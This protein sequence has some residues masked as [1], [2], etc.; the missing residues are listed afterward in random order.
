MKPAVGFL[1]LMLT[2]AAPDT[3]YF[4]FQREIARSAEAKAGQ[5]CV[6]LDPAIFAHSASQLADLRLYRDGVA[7]TPYVVRT[8]ESSEGEQRSISLLNLGKR[9]AETVFDAEMPGAR[10]SDVELTVA[11]KDFIAAVT[12][13]GSR[14]QSGDQ[15]RLGV[16]TIFD[17][18]GQKLGRSTVL[19]LPKS[20]FRYLHFRVKGALAPDAFNGIWVERLPENSAK[21]VTVAET[22]R[23]VQKGKSTSVEF[24]VPAHVPV[25]RVTFVA[26]AAPALFSRE[27]RV[28]VNAATTPSG[29]PG[30]G[31]ETGEPR[32]LQ[33]FTGALLR[34]HGVRDG[35]RIDE[36]RLSI[37]APRSEMDVAATWT[38]E[39]DNGDDAPLQW[40]AVRLEMLV[41][42]ACFEAAPGAHYKLK[43]GDS[44]LARPQ[45]DYAALFSPQAE[46]LIGIAGAE[47]ANPAHRE[48]PDAR[49]FTERHPALLWTGLLVAVG[50]LGAIALRSGTH[51]VSH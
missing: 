47:Q 38:I 37:D 13:S 46:A 19:H 12:V 32:S 21:Y 11:V 22:S 30:V 24:T 18:T 4:R 28:R 10:Y 40:A 31:S 43:Y 49:P 8:S 3:R 44:A 50:V 14:T 34:V 41:R 27:A 48:R 45:Y 9:G 1:L 25:D 23:A 17:L 20:D 36:E 16:Y 35:Q 26:G 2:A 15:T 51:H 29:R 33:T 7:E 5:T 42:S 6:A 39:I